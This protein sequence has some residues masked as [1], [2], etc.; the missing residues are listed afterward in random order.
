MSVLKVEITEEHLT[1]LKNLNWSLKDNV[2]SGVGHD[3]DDEIPAFGQ[4][5]LYEAMALILDGKPKEFDPFNAEDEAEYS[6]EF[7]AKCEKLYSELPL[8]LEVILQ[9]QTFPIGT[10]KAKFHDRVWK[11]IK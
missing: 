5:N 9:T 7:K 11:R 2:I 4:N 1:L 10:F 3:G 6:E 8:A